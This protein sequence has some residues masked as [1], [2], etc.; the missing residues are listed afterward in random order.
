VCGPPLSFLTTSTVYSDHVSCRSVAPCNRSWGSPRCWL[1]LSGALLPGVAAGRHRSKRARAFPV[2]PYPAK[3]SPRHQ[4][5]V[6]SPRPI[7]SRRCCRFW[8]PVRRCCHLHTDRWYASAQPQGLVPVPSPLPY[9]GVATRMQLDAPM[10]LFPQG[11][12]SAR[13]RSLTRKGCWLEAWGDGGDRFGSHSGFDVDRPK[14]IVASPWGVGESSGGSP[15]AGFPVRRPGC[16]CSLNVS[17]QRTATL[18]CGRGVWGEGSSLGSDQQELE[19]P[20]AGDRCRLPSHSRAPGDVVGS[21]GW[22]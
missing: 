10:G 11:G 8:L 13:L 16:V 21:G 7:P 2:V 22:R 17:V 9:P 5:C 12:V 6:V 1:V 14:W 15:E 3:L 18:G 19:A 4:L 20:C